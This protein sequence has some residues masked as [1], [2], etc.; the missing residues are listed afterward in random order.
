MILEMATGEI[1][2]EPIPT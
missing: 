2:W 1:R